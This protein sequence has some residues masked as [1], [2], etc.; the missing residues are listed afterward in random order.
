M[1]ETQCVG[2]SHVHS[3][4]REVALRSQC[5]KAE[6]QRHSIS[7]GA[8]CHPCQLLD[9]QSYFVLA[10]HWIGRDDSRREIMEKGW[11]NPLHAS[12]RM[13][14]TLPCQLL[15]AYKYC[16]ICNHVILINMV[17]YI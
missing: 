14:Y 3:S 17:E 9:D 6:C 13:V 16:D 4:E 11:F 15:I 10:N 7:Y 12:A 5:S 1:V 8:S 2:V